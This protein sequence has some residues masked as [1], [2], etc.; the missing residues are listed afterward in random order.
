ME[1]K[2]TIKQRLLKCKDY[3][4]LCVFTA[5]EDFKFNTSKF[6]YFYFRAFKN[7]VQCV[8]FYLHFNDFMSDAIQLVPTFETSTLRL[9]INVYLFEDT[10]EGNRQNLICSIPVDN[11]FNFYII[12]N[13]VL[14][15]LKRLGYLNELPF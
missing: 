14:L 10:P 4:S 11:V 3:N 8:Q 2:L 12:L 1:K 15:C 5:S 13:R 6:H 9:R 7:F